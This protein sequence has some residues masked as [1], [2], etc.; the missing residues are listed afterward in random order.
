MSGGKAESFAGF[1]S[2]AV[3]GALSG[4]WTMMLAGPVL[5]A[6]AFAVVAVPIVL[7]SARVRAEA[8][9]GGV[10]ARLSQGFALAVPF[11]TLALASRFGLGWNAGTAF[12]GAAIAASA[13]A[14]GLELI[15][16]GCGKITGLLLPGLW[17]ALV[18]SAW[19]MVAAMLTGGAA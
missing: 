8:G 12:S 3:L 13:G 19:I 15:K 11:A 1:A 14:G 2:L 7:F 9:L 18:A 17:G 16:A 4:G 5:V 10:I 6:L